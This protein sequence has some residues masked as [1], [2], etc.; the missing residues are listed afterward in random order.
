MSLLP[1]VLALSPAPAA[2]ADWWWVQ[3]NP[4]DA[5]IIFAD[6][7]SVSRAGDR[8]TVRVLSLDRMG[9][10][11]ERTLTVTCPA[12]RQEGPARFAC[13]SEAERMGWAAMLGGTSPRDSA[14]ALFASRAQPGLA[15]R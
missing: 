6:G 11:V 7:R 2:T 1:L 15:R 3:G 13:D 4:E 14:R 12:P 5:A 9:Q 8:A 10:A